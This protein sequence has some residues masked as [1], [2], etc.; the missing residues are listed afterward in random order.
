VTFTCAR[1]RVGFAALAFALAC[2][3]ATGASAERPPL[4]EQSR[5]SS[6]G[7]GDHSASGVEDEAPLVG[8]VPPE[9]GRVVLHAGAGMAVLLPHVTGAVQLGLGARVG[10]ELGYRTV[11]GL[12]HKG[13]LGVRWSAPVTRSVSIGV[14]AR[15]AL[16]TLGPADGLVGIEFSNVAL[17]NDWEVGHDLLLSWRRPGQAHVT[18]AIG[19]TYTLGG[20]RST[21]Y[22]ETD[23]EI[24][25]D[26]RAIDA[27]VRGEWALGPRLNL[28]LSLEGTVLLG[29][30]TDDACIEARQ[31]N[32]GQI[33]PI[34]FLPTSSAGLAWSA[35]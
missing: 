13:K 20:P 2:G 32:C 27:E 15:T 10:L 3:K 9:A 28:V 21:S 30:E 35:W 14:A 18:A 4:D 7:A 19:P 6:A 23:F 33:A 11:A 24:T 5:G 12:S 26:F 29:I 1:P 31:R 25:P 17:A 8:A 22:D 34:G 16:G